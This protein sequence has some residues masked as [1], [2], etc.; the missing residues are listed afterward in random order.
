MKNNAKLKYFLSD[1]SFRFNGVCSSIAKTDNPTIQ[2]FPSNNYTCSINTLENSVTVVFSNVINSAFSIRI[3]VYIMNPS[4][5]IQSGYI[6]TLLLYAENNI[7]AETGSSSVV[8]KTVNLPLSLNKLN[9][10]WNINPS[11]SS[12]FQFA[13]KIVRCDAASPAYYPYNSFILNFMV[14]N[15]TPSNVKLRV[16][17]NLF[18]ETGATFL[19]GSI[20]ET[21]PSYDSNTKVSCK[22]TSNSDTSRKI[23]CTG[24]GR[25]MASTIYK[26]GFKM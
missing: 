17:I 26:I 20:S 11:N 19:I 5:V 16:N 23:Q 2:A 22:L 13:M 4:R 9:L 18:T 8:L 3:Q 24:V 6:K 14:G 25:L 12:S 15:S 10:A 1:N 21:L 7:I